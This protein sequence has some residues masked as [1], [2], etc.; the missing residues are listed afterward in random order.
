MAELSKFL[1]QFKWRRS[2][3]SGV[4]GQQPVPLESERKLRL[5]LG[6]D[7]GTSFTKICYRDLGSEQSGVI[8]FSSGRDR[9]WEEALID[10]RLFLSSGDHIRAG[11]PGNGNESSYDR[12]VDSMKMR[13][14]HLDLAEELKEFNFSRIGEEKSPEWA[15]NMS[16]VFLANVLISSK[17]WLKAN[18]PDLF[19]GRSPVWSAS[20]GVPVQVQDS[21]ALERF[22][23]VFGWAWV[24]AVSASSPFSDVQTACRMINEVRKG[25]PQIDADIHAYPEI[26][27]AV[28]S[29]VSSPTA[30]EGMYMYFDIGGGTL[31]GVTFRLRRDGGSKKIDFY[32]SEIQPEGVESLV[33]DVPPEHRADILSLLETGDDENFSDVFDTHK[34]RIHR[35]VAGVLIETKKKIRSEWAEAFRRSDWYS[36]LKAGERPTKQFMLPLFL[37][38]GGCRLRFFKEAIYDTHWAHKLERTNIPKFTILPLPPPTDLDLGNVPE[39]EFHRF[40]IA[41][42]LSFDFG[43]TPDVELPKNFKE[44]PRAKISEPTVAGHYED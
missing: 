37:G 10:S 32:Y 14:A 22:K 36:A 23:K 7:F 20:V 25:G 34:R 6:I 19:V 43:E 21:P 39:D 33:N 44:E 27:A 42:G 11:V 4:E 26:A 35:Q 1:G 13:L 3:L 29:F 28:L 8:D 9:D 15:E 31:D 41:Y 2:R 30:R 5:N 16:C 12:I 17:N 24:L 18:K 38:G 40:A